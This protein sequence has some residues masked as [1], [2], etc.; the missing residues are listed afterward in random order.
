MYLYNYFKFYFE[1]NFSMF[2][3]FNV[4]RQYLFDIILKNLFKNY[5]REYLFDIFLKEKSSEQIGLKGSML[6]LGK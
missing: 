5:F 1:N 6:I 4:F 3:F 2:K